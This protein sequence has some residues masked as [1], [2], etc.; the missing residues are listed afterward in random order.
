VLRHGKKIKIM[1]ALSSE[2][3]IVGIIQ[4]I[5]VKSGSGTN[6]I[7]DHTGRI[8]YLLDMK[9]EPKREHSIRNE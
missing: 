5:L 2:Y 7:L 4:V 6:L 9:A 8:S 1:S 3:F